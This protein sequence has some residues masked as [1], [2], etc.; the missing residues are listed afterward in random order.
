MNL[1]KCF[2][3]QISFIAR[4]VASCCESFLFFLSHIWEPFHPFP[5]NHALVC[6]LSNGALG[7]QMNSRSDQPLL[8][9]SDHHN[10]IHVT[11]FLFL[12]ISLW[13]Q[14]MIHWSFYKSYFGLL[15][16]YRPFLNIMFDS[17]WL[18]NISPTITR[19]P[20]LLLCEGMLRMGH[21]EVITYITHPH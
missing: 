2:P 6:Q 13:P 16:K 4:R 18:I 19:S 11:S 10:P 7:D 21:L 17:L 20:L 12:M 5:P 9:T 1:V 8:V 3:V 14:H 15:I